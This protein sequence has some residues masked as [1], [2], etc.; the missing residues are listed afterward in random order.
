M[1]ELEFIKAFSKITIRS[2]CLECKVDYSNLFAG[3]SSNENEI[4]VRDL[5][6][7]RIYELLEEYHG[8]SEDNTL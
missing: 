3:R 4:K 1:T 2:V 6:E 5:I 7:K 8:E